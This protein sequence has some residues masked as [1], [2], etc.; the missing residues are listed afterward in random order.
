MNVILAKKKKNAYGLVYHI[1]CTNFGQNFT[2][3]IRFQYNIKI[4]LGLHEPFFFA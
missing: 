2:G 4:E 1:K 3:Y